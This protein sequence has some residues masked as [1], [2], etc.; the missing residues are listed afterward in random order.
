MYSSCS[1]LKNCNG[2]PG[3]RTVTAAQSW[4]HCTHVYVGRSPPPNTH[5][6]HAHHTHLFDSALRGLNVAIQHHDEFDV[7]VGDIPVPAGRWSSPQP[8]EGGWRAR[9]CSWMEE[10]VDSEPWALSGVLNQRQTRDGG[11]FYTPKS[12]VGY[13]KPRK[14]LGRFWAAAGS[15]R[16]VA[17]ARGSESSAG[18]AGQRVEGGVRART[19]LLDDIEPG[20]D[21]VVQLRAS[22]HR[23]A[24]MLQE[25]ADVQRVVERAD[26]RHRHAR[27]RQLLTS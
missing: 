24:R 21:D 6:P 5:T 17:A 14:R 1:C 4:A 10:V 13:S 18:T 16:G 25:R 22:I 2:P 7:G 27:H 8:R 23:H 19:S 26:H 11:C 15:Q 20:V 3:H 12:S 9:W